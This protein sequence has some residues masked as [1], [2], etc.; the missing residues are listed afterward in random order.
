[1]FI[2]KRASRLRTAIGEGYPA[3]A[4]NSKPARTAR[5]DAD[6]ICAA[7]AAGRHT[8]LHKFGRECHAPGMAALSICLMFCR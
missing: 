5:A 3:D 8:A 4:A 7:T 2:F 6:H 1:M